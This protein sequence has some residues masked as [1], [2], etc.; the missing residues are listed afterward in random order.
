[1]DAATEPS[2]RLALALHRATGL[3]DRVAD[4]YLQPAHGLSISMFSAMVAIDAVGPARQSAIARALDVTRAAVTQRLVELVSRGLV[5]VVPDPLDSRANLVSL[6]EAGRRVL[7]E[8]WAGLARSDD[9]LERGVDL[10]ALQAAL[11][12]LIANAERYL[13]DKEATR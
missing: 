13:A 4:A 1:M 11:D 3:V 9:G 2:Q 5:D 7:S 10:T 8:A 12:A 6:S